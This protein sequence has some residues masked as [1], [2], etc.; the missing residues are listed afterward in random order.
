MNPQGP[1]LL[2]N[3]VPIILIFAIF[4]FLII[5]PQQKQEKAR[6]KMLAEVKPNDK[7]L[8]TG[9]IIGTIAAINGNEIELKVAPNV[10]V[11]IVRSA[12]MSVLKDDAPAA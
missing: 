9:G 12:V 5:R 7:I 2:A 6:Q 10:K 3:I 11:T 1:S 8:T 4:Y